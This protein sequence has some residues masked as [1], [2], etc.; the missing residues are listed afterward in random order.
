ME[1]SFG[2]D[3]LL[4]EKCNLHCKFCLESHANNTID[5]N[6]IQSLPNRLCDRF[7]QETNTHPNIERISFRIWGGELFADSLKDFMFDEYENLVNNIKYKFKSAVPD[8]KL[9]FAFVSNGVFNKVDRVESLL[10]NTGSSLNLSYDSYGRFNKESQEDLMIDNAKNF[11]KAGLLDEISITLI[12]PSIIEY[13]NNHS[14]LL[15]LSFAKRIDINYY[16]PN[17]NWK[18]LLPSDDD[19]YDFFKWALDNKLYQVIDLHN[20]LRALSGKD[21]TCIKGCN[22]HNHISA[23]KDCTTYNCVKSSTILPNSDFYGDAVI[24]E[25]N[26]S[27]LKRNKGMSKRGCLMCEHFSRCPGCCWTSVIFKHAQLQE[28]PFARTIEY[29]KDNQSILESF[30]KWNS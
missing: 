14:R 19:L 20:M 15:E 10:I 7:L 21:K 12:K 29:I 2:F 25:E 1:N 22:C 18:T 28:C 30:N 26:V 3:C 13:I 27:S 16:I 17:V 4:F 23:C 24:T 8:K 11:H 6:W 5:L 9:S